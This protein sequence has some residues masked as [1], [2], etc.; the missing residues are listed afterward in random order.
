MADPGVS[1]QNFLRLLLGGAQKGVDQ[2]PQQQAQQAD[3]T[4]ALQRMMQQNQQFGEQLTQRR[5][6]A[7]EAG[8]DRDADREAQ[9]TRDAA[10]AAFREKVLDIN[11]QADATAAQVKVDTA[12]Q[13]RRKDFDA[14]VEARVN[15]R[16]KRLSDDEFE[17]LTE[18][19][20]QGLRL[21]E[22]MRIAGSL[23]YGD[24]LQELALQQGVRGRRGRTGM[25]TEVLGPPIPG[26]P[27][28][29]AAHRSA[30]SAKK[31]PVTAKKGVDS[32]QAE[33]DS[34]KAY[35]RERGYEL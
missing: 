10:T 21:T 29:E 7:T 33:I 22:G 26:S 18:D 32:I 11:T 12:D 23:G 25:G 20:V 34:T 13:K 14:R 30:E 4:L 8:S 19:E 1:G 5:D 35:L 15:Q 28:A 9:A 31:G 16:I 24:I 6:I 2:I 3:L 17:K 27:A